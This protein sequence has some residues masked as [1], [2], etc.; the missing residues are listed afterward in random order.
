MGIAN[1][2]D[3]ALLNIISRSRAKVW[4]LLSDETETEPG[5]TAELFTMKIS[6]GTESIASEKL[7]TIDWPLVAVRRRNVGVSSTAYKATV[8]L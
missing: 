1:F 7:T 5:V 4:V 8:E 6:C 2:Y 3:I